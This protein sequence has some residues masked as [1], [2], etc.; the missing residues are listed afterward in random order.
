[1]K[2]LISACLATLVGLSGTASAD[3]LYS[4]DFESNSAGFSGP[5]AL[6]ATSGYSSYG[7][8]RQLLWNSSGAS[9]YSGTSSTLTLNLAQAA[10]GATLGFSL[11]IVDSW[12]GTGSW[13]CGY[14]RFNVALDGQVIFSR[15]FGAYGTNGPE[16]TGTGLATLYYGPSDLFASSWSDAAYAV[17]LALGDLAAGQH[18]LDFFASSAEGG[19]QAGWDESF[20]L[21]NVSVN[22]RLGT[23]DT[24]V[25][26]PSVFALLGIGLISAALTRRRQA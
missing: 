23:P 2:T 21:D 4:N 16:T 20:A 13:C 7:F 24:N 17:N 3:V 9:A 26:E 11:G 22:G 6:A 8:G 1:M 25:P 19:W 18:T 15:I 12:D 10:R 5:G 14:D